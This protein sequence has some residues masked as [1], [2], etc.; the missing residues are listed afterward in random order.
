MQIYNFKDKTLINWCNRPP[1]SSCRALTSYLCSVA[2]NS[3]MP[4]FAFPRVCVWLSMPC[5]VWSCIFTLTAGLI[6]N[7]YSS[8]ALKW[9]YPLVWHLQPWP[10]A[11]ERETGWVRE[12][13]QKSSAPACTVTSGIKVAEANGHAARQH[14]PPTVTDWLSQLHNQG[15]VWRLF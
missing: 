1:L 7:Y 4:C 10:R 15:Q 8:L 12:L 9:A 13:T 11:W 14:L 6:I 5:L 2:C 3:L